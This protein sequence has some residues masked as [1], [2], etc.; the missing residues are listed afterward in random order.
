MANISQTFV[1]GAYINIPSLFIGENYPFWKI[2]MKIFLELVD[3]GVWKVVVNGLCQ[4]MKIENGKNKPKEFSQWTPD[5]NKKEHYDVKA[6]NIISFTLTLDEFY[7]IFI[8]ESIKEM[9]DVLE[10]THEGTCQVKSSRKNTLSKK[11]NV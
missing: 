1:E 4:P 8:C 11:Q 7:K 10:M 3:K 2:K 5:E 6:K 9:C